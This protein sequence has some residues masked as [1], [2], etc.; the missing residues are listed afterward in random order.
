MSLLAALIFKNSYILAATYFIFLKNWPIPNLKGFQYQIGT[1]VKRS[2]KQLSSKTNLSAFLRVICSNIRLKLCLRVTKIV[3]LFKFE[4]IWG[5]VEAIKQ[6]CT[7][8][9]RQTLVFMWNSTLREKFNFYFSVDFSYIRNSASNGFFKE[10]V[11]V[12]IWNK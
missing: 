5:Q 9:L 8:Y 1:S 7:K 4:R 3:K 6:S 12:S 10:Q 2:G 11:H